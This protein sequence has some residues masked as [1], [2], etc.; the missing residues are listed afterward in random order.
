VP[1][2]WRDDRRAWWM[3]P[4]PGGGD[5]ILLVGADSGDQ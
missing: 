1:T 2:I 5:V 4:L 3:V